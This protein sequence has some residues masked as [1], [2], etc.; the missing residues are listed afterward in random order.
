LLEKLLRQ[1]WF[2]WQPRVGDSEWNMQYAF[3]GHMV[4]LCDQE[5]ASDGE[6]FTEGFHRFKLGK[7]IGVRTW[8]GEIWLS[9]SESDG[10]IATAAELGIYGPEEK[11]LI[12]GCRAGHRHRQSS[13][14]DLRR[15]RCTAQSGAG[16]IETR[17]Q[18]RPKA[19]AAA[20]G[21]SEQGLSVQTLNQF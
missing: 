7:T 11:W 16:A 1:A 3:R 2:Y 15:R 13:A 14:R 21:L 17:D 8:G 12:E 18:Q 9:S 4:V 10:G 5:T 6:A 20:A 19:G